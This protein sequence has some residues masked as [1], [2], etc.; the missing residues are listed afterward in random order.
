MKCVNHAK[1]T[2]NCDFCEFFCGERGEKVMNMN[3]LIANALC[4]MI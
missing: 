3:I 1:F 2:K 4:K